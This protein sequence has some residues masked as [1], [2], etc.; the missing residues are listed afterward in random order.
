VEP[1]VDF[2]PDQAGIA[3][4]A[5][6]G[7]TVFVGSLTGERVHIAALDA[8]GRLEDT[9]QSVLESEYGRLRTVVLDAAGGLWITTSNRDGAGEPVEDDDK[10]LR[11]VPP[12]AGGSSPL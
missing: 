11:I 12:T 4:C 3:G 10:V 8:N 1:T 2:P 9:P 7:T 5:V 6:A